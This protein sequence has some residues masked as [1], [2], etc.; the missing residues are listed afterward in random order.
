[1]LTLQCLL[2]G[3][4]Q[5]LGVFSNANTTMPV[6]WGSSVTWCVLQ[7]VLQC[8]HRKPLENVVQTDERAAYCK[9]ECCSN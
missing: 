8:Q 9:V 5:L 4:A 2:F 1:M 7:C 6:V 3:V